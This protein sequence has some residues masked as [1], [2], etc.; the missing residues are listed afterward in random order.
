MLILLPSCVVQELQLSGNC[1]AELPDGISRLTGL[2][3]L[4]LAGNCLRALPPGLGALRALEGLW[5]HGNLLEGELPAELGGLAALR[6]LSLAGGAGTGR[7]WRHGVCG[8]AGR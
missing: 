8:A 3:R 2:R 5:L 7:G 6:A 1:L 4:G